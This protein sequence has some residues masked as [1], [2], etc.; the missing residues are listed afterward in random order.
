MACGLFRGTKTIM[1]DK[2][3]EN[4]AMA[5]GASPDASGSAKTS[6]GPYSS[7]WV[8][9]HCLGFGTCWGWVHLAFFSTMF[10]GVMPESLSLSSWILNVLSN[11][12]AMVVLGL[13]SL[14]CP[15]RTFRRLGPLFATLT[16][17]GT[18]GFFFGQSLSAMWV[19]AAAVS[20]GFGTAGLLLLWAEAYR[21]IPPALAKQRTIPG[22]L[23]M[24]VLYYLLIC[25]LPQLVG[26][27]VT[28]LLPVISVALLQLTRRM[29]H[30]GE[31][32]A[33]QRSDCSADLVVDGVGGESPARKK[34]RLGVIRGA[35]SVRFAIFVGVYCL[36][37]GFMRGYTSALPFA[38]SGG[39]GEAMFS[40]V[41][42]VLVVL[43]VASIALFGE[44]KIDLAYKFV[45]P[46]MAAGLFLLPFLSAGQEA[47]ASVVIMSGYTLLEIYVWASLA[48]SAANTSA[49]TALVFGLGKSCMNVGLLA[50]TFLG[51]NFGS[52][53][54]M[55]MVG[56]MVLIVYLFIVIENVMSPGI[57]V[58]L[59]LG[60][61]NQDEREQGKRATKPE[62]VTIE[63][64]AKLNLSDVFNAML[65]ERCSLVAD[66]YGLSARETEV[67]GQL[68]RGRSLQAIADDLCV[69]YSTVK[70]HT[71]RIYAKTGVHS[72]QDLISLLENSVE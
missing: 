4:G 67:L 32:D 39:I 16:V 60:L 30:D 61:G 25:M 72:R 41:A 44:A 31:E 27:V 24:G 36:A 64:A 13:L 66:R 10:F 58:A 43:A 47:L 50:G 15:L 5:N 34:S 37:P 52:S 56:V 8:L 7:E 21:D 19:Y 65:N 45:V 33:S 14:W 3:G 48:D 51:M 35:V 6:K 40:G 1:P 38:S 28:M 62:K 53:S 2:S 55:L 9:I 20:S 29:G 49:P 63:E 71:D 11:G 46:L 54:S 12:F 17:L 42:I 18:I 70:T 26:V 23:A 59:S 57:G 69:A 68:A 22:S